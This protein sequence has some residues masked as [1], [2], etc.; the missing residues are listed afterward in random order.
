MSSSISSV[1]ER[2][3]ATPHGVTTT[4]TAPAG[5][6]GDAADGRKAA[7][8][9]RGT[10]ATVT[11]AA[12]GLT[13]ETIT[14]DIVGLDSTDVDDGPNTYPVGV[15]VCAT[16]GSTSGI[17]VT[18]TWDSFNPYLNLLGTSVLTIASLADGTCADRYFFVVV[19]R[20][21]AAYDT[22][23]SYHVTATADGVP[24]VST[25]VPRQLY[26]EKLLSQNRNSVLS[27]EGPTT[28]YEGET[29]T[30]TVTA[31]TAP[32]GYSQ[33]TT[34]L[35]MLGPIFQ[36]ID[37]ELT[38][39]NPAGTQSSPYVDACGWDPDSSS[40][41]YRS[42]VGPEKVPGGAAGGALIGTFSGVVVGT[43]STTMS[44]A[45]IDVSG[46]SYHYNTDYGTAPNLIAVVSLPTAD[47]ALTK[48]AVGSFIAGTTGAFRLTVGNLGPSASGTPV[49]VTDSLPAG[50]TFLDS[51]GDGWTCSAAGQ[52]VTCT[53]AAALAAGTSSS[54][55]ILVS[56]ADSLVGATVNS[57]V[58]S[59][60][61]RDV[62]PAN[63]A[64]TA[65]ATV[66]TL[67]EARA[68]TPEAVSRSGAR[69]D[70]AATGAG[71]V[72][73]AAAGAARP[74]S[75]A[76]TGAGDS[77]TLTLLGIA[78]VGAGVVVRRAGRRRSA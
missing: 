57:A 30:Y 29:V 6:A 70:S 11:A 24:T 50:M 41:T 69:T 18:F 76:V 16:G 77:A 37:V 1:P 53:H 19:T 7:K 52:Q 49:V 3:Q 38:Y 36:L 45:I 40:P 43:G 65:R 44:N 63:N 42:C 58:V 28:V 31:S 74:Q 14:W 2:S 72:A 66:V 13:I 34:F 21:E 9:E 46:S 47:L 62:V 27:V 39:E 59:G 35:A 10:S 25:P 67:E 75:L 64:A 78:L 61:A 8:A 26:V 20:D 60:P 22:T 71:A 54:V 15:R 23:R 32:N 12:V 68:T 33:L 73:A 51:A 56:L 17:T 55:T 5:A 48:A 4:T